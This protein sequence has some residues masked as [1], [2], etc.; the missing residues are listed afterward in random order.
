[1]EKTEK[2]V[3]GDILHAVF[4]L[5]VVVADLDAQIAGMRQAFGIEP[6]LVQE[7]QYPDL[8]YRGEEI[9]SWS[10]IAKYDHFGVLIEFVQPMGDDSM[11]SDAVKASPNGCVLHHIRF[12]DVPDNDALTAMMEERGVQ[13]LQ[14]GGSVVHPGSKFTF[15][16]TEKLLGFVTE[17][18][19]AQ[20]EHE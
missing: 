18:V 5:G 20:P 13:K 15:Y 11:W 8:Y 17:V 2:Q 3:P 6:C 1:M 7:C 14:E 10:R 9:H 19:T 16:D 12:N 4:Q